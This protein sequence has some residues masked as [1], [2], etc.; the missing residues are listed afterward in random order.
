MTKRR[1]ISP[2]FKHGAIEQVIQPGVTCAQVAR[3]L[4]IN[5]NQLY[6]WK[7]EVEKDGRHAFGRSTYRCS[8]SAA[9]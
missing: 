2:E 4:G 3:E 9:A 5:P 6:R 8:E 1:K 7:C